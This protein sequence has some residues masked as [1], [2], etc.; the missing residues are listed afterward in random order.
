MTMKYDLVLLH[1]PSVYDFRKNPLLAGPIS[2]VVPSS[3][4]FEMYPIGLTSIAD[5]LERF[6]L[7]VKIINIANR[8]LM[9]QNFDVEKKLKGIQTKAFG[10]DLH[11]LPHAH[12]SIELAK[13][14]KGLHPTVPIIFGGLSATY[15]HQELI[16]YPFV[17]FVMRGDSTEKLMLLLMNKLEAGNNRYTDIPN[18]TWKNGQE[19]G[20]NPLTYVPK[21][22][23]EFDVPGYR[24]TVR[25]VFKYR[26]FLDPLPYNGWLQYPNTALLTARG[27]T[28]NCLICGGSREAYGQNCNRNSLALRSPAKLIEDIQFIQRFSRAPIFI[29]HDLRQGGKEYVDEFFRRLKKAKPKN[30]IVFELFQYADEDYFTKINESVPKYSIEITL[31]TH[32]EDLRKL[33]GKFNCTNQKV[34]DTL[35]FALKHGCKKIDLFFMVGIPGQTYESALKNIE[36]CETLHQACGLDP[37][38]FYFV[39]PLAP[40]LDP[41]SPAFERPELYGYKKFCHTLED[42]RKAITQP[43]WKHMLSYETKEMTRDDIVN[44]TYESA[45]LLNEFKLNFGLIDEEGYMDIDRKIQKSIEYIGKIDML[46]TLPEAQK[47]KALVKLGKEIEE[48]NRYSICGKNELKWEVQKN[49]ANFFSLA[50]VGLEQ[51]YE[52]YAIKFRSQFRP[53]RREQVTVETK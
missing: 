44:A 2:D 8:M 12:G 15:Y 39:A 32:D 24:Y 35:N 23:D 41:A 31:E 19:I 9:D 53:K 50:L 43:S 34:I 40:F 45:K 18:L 52:D 29:L 4:V 28:Q 25:S 5:F 51:L 37:R 22:L 1:A 47:A 21:D 7:R 20:Y 3:P 13:L 26:N 48:L 17:D 46:L 11:W 36:F 10:I 30:E 38:I 16:Q 14:V 33:N 27:C 6:G 42:H 49:Y